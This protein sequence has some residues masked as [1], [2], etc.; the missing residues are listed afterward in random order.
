MKCGL[1][2]DFMGD[3]RNGGTRK[4]RRGTVQGRRCVDRARKTK[5]ATIDRR[6]LGRKRGLNKRYQVRRHAHGNEHERKASNNEV[7]RGDRLK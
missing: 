4:A 6:G 7:E 1:T 3:S 2:L 5:R